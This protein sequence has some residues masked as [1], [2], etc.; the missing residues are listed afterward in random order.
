LLKTSARRLGNGPRAKQ[1]RFLGKVSD[2]RL[3]ELYRQASATIY[4][5]LYE[6]FG[7]PVLDSLR[8]GTPVL[9]A[10]NSSLGEFEG[11]GV[12]Y[13]DATDPSSLDEAYKVFLATKTGSLE[14]ADLDRRLNWDNMART[15]STLCA[16]QEDQE[17]ATPKRL[18]VA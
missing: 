9:C 14:R 6:G 4:P 13:F 11:P 7:F 10:Y 1:V 2:R 12:H 8:H 16:E 17:L 18:A 15:I 3:C 5:S